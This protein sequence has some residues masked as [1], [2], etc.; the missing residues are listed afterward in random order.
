[1]SHEATL[2]RSP[3]NLTGIPAR[4]ILHRPGG[5]PAH[6]GA[7]LESGCDRRPYVI[8]DAS[9]DLFE[10]RLSVGGEVPTGIPALVRIAEASKP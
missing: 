1:M 2:L 8:H 6:H 4:R 3:L 5:H 9:A 7:R 10:M